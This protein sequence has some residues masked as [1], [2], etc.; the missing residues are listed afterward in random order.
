M[1]IT[2]ALLDEGDLIDAGFSKL[3]EVRAHLVRRANAAG[4]GILR[5]GIL[6]GL[7]V[8]PDVRA[9][10]LVLTENVM[11]AERVA[12]ELEAVEAAAPR[13]VAIAMH[14]KSCHHADVRIHRMADRHTLFPED[15]I[16][17]VHPLLG[18]SGINKGKRQRADAKPRSE[19]DCLAVRA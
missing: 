19:L 10:R 18:F 13:F 6:H 2:A 12:E 11:M 16:V 4:A 15:T 14:G 17:V 5:H 1:P 3:T 7:E 8:L 9:P